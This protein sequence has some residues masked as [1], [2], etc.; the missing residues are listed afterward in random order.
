MTIYLAVFVGALVYALI[1]FVS[2]NHKEVLTAK[3]ALIVLANVVAGAAL[4]WM[5]DLQKIE[6]M[7]NGFD[8]AKVVG[9]TF[10]IFGQKLFKA[11]VKIAD[12]RIRTKIGLNED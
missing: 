5:L 4:V 11:V 9:A 10:G 1:D 2:D 12:K 8:F 7:Y 3:Y 6:L